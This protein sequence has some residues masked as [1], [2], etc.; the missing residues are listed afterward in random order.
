M[1]KSEDI[2]LMLIEILSNHNQSI[3]YAPSAPDAAK[4]RRLLRRYAYTNLSL[5]L[6]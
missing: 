2:A 4:L 1:S 5:A 6:P 3:N